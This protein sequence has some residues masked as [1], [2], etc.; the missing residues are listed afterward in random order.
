MARGDNEY[1][2]MGDGMTGADRLSAGLIPGLTDVRQ[3]AAG[4]VSGYALGGTHRSKR[5]G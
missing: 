3:I 2:Q 4:A 5:G 1:G